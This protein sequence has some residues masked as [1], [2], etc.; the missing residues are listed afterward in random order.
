VRH[1]AAAYVLRDF[2]RAYDL[3]YGSQVFALAFLNGCASATVAEIRRFYD[4]AAAQYPE[5]YVQGGGYSFEQWVE[6]MK[7]TLLLRDHARGYEIT[8]FGHEFVLHLARTQ[9]TAFKKY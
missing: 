7:K 8:R 3:I 9:R 4:D 2:E 1:L 5:V 6:F